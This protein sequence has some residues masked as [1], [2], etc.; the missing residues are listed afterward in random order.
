MQNDIDICDV[1]EGIG[2]QTLNFGSGLLLETIN[3]LTITG[4]YTL[5]A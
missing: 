2:Q 5:P 3:R 4:H 1:C